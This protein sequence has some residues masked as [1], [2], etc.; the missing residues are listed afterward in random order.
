MHDTI[1]LTLIL[2]V[3]VFFILLKPHHGFI[4][5][6]GNPETL[7]CPCGPYRM[8]LCWSIRCWY[9]RDWLIPKYEE[10]SKLLDEVREVMIISFSYLLCCKIIRYRLVTPSIRLFCIADTTTA[11]KRSE[12]MGAWMIW[13][14]SHPV[15]FK[16]LR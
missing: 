1:K 3:Q 12:D 8:S 13:V 11:L 5:D 7:L 14:R 9:R 15:L 2:N 10:I 16:I 6:Q 4:T